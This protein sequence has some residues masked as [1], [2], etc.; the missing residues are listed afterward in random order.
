VL[1]KDAR[2]ITQFFNTAAFALPSKGTLGNEARYSFRGPGINNWDIALFK[3]FKIKE[4]VQT[5]FRLETYNTF[6]HTQ[7]STLDTAAKFD[8]T[9]K[10]TNTRFGQ[11]TAARNPRRLQLALKL[12]F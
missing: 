9:G 5:Q 12:T 11:I 2:S 8:A 7:F 3:N 6:N 10:Q 4:R 1:S